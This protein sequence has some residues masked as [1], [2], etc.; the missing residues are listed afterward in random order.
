L[1]AN[2]EDTSTQVIV[3]ESEKTPG[4][5]KEKIRDGR[6]SQKAPTPGSRARKE[7]RGS[8]SKI[9]KKAASI[10][11]LLTEHD[12]QENLRVIR[13]GKKATHRI[14]DGELKRLIEVPDHKTRLAAV[15]L[16]LAYREGKPVEK[17]LT[18]HA[19]VEDF[20]AMVDKL[21]ASPAFQAKIS[22]QKALEGE[23]STFPAS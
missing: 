19:D 17:S 7:I 14:Y 15:A 5:I 23:Q 2:P 20:Q 3:I 18:V 8:L 22:E 10:S 16:D 11:Q 12:Q 6:Y 13:E 1:K 9:I 4:Y 21:N